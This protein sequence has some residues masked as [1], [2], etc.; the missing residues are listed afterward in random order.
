MHLLVAG[1]QKCLGGPP[2]MS[3]LAISDQ[4]WAMIEVNLHP[5]GSKR[6]RK[7]RSLPTLGGLFKGR[8]DGAGRDP[9]LTAAIA[10]PA[11]GVML[12]VLGVI[13]VQV[14]DP[15]GTESVGLLDCRHHVGLFEVHV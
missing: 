8:G 1:P 4:A 6:R 13:G 3:L 15:F 12:V 2:G 14:T 9:W 10:V 5:E 7:A 11:I